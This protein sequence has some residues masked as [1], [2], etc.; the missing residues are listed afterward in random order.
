MVYS[1]KGYK[2]VTCF[3]GADITKGHASKGGSNNGPNSASIVPHSVLAFASLFGREGDHQML[4]PFLL[5][6][7]IWGVHTLDSNE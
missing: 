1:E 7:V 3:C 5:I 4:L 6:Q 2:S